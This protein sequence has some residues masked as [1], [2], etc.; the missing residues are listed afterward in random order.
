M[1]EHAFLAE[2]T[3]NCHCRKPAG[4]TSG[5]TRRHVER[6]P[7][8]A[9]RLELV[10]APA[11]CLAV[12]E[13]V[14]RHV[15]PVQQPE[16]GGGARPGHRGVRSGTPGV[17]SATA[18]AAS[19]GG[20]K[21]P[22]IRPSAPS[23]GPGHEV[24]PRHR[25]GV[26]VV[27][28]SFRSVRSI[29]GRATRSVSTSSPAA[30]RCAAANRRLEDDAG[31]ADAA[32]GGPE[33]LGSLIVTRPDVEHL[34]VGGEAERSNVMANEPVDV[35]V[36]AVHVGCDGTADGDEPRARA[37]RHEAARG[38][39]GAIN[40]SRLVPAGTVTAPSTQVE[41]V[42]PVPVV[43]THDATGVLR[44]VAVGRARG[45]GRSPLVADVAT[46]AASSST[47]AGPRDRRAAEGSDRPHPLSSRRGHS[48]GGRSCGYM[49]KPNTTSHTTP[50][51][52][53]GP[54]GQH[55]LLGR[56]ALALVERAV[57][58][59][60]WPRTNGR[61]DSWYQGTLAVDSCRPS[62]TPRGSTPTRTAPDD[63]D[64]R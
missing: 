61:I 56:L 37:H 41:P 4:R 36:L 51:T 1:P 13:L 39:T 58:T 29:R 14:E 62:R 25:V 45:H 28:P 49:P 3:T 27:V 8:G 26:V 22:R 30:S 32:R 15:L 48:C 54:V 11:R 43:S 5:S 33:Q 17:G 12:P 38:T 50:M 57:R 24:D 53:S 19:S 35:V 42:A 9:D 55:D 44:G 23:S 7:E 10:A 18:G 47:C 34:P 64:R 6:V 20:A 63:T 59:G 60:G 31:Q 40:S 2:G 52:W 21:S 16:D 46:P